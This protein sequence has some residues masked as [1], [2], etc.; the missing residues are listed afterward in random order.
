MCV[1][2]IVLKKMAEHRIGRNAL[3]G[4]NS[5]VKRVDRTLGVLTSGTF[6]AKLRPEAPDSK[7]SASSNSDDSEESDGWETD[8][9][10]EEVC[11]FAF[12]SVLF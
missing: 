2:L 12:S 9:E 8:L 7:R 4:K 3:R 11:V 6:T 1:H 5:T 10:C